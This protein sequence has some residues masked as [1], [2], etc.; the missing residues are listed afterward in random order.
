MSR[1]R[2]PI[3][4]VTGKVRY[5]E[6]RDVKFALRRADGDRS[7][8][9]L[10]EVSCSRRET[11]GYPCSNCGGWHLTSQPTRFSLIAAPRPKFAE[12]MPGPA[13]EAIR[14]MATGP[15]LTAGVAA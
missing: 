14:R 5:R 11:T 12:H 9:R 1:H 10:N 13:A 6:R 7:K 4:Q 3:C 15:R 8:A 2:N